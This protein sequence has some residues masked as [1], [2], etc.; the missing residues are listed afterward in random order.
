MQPSESRTLSGREVARDVF[1]LPKS[2]LL[3]HLRREGSI[4]GLP[5]IRIGRNWIFPRSAI[6]RLLPPCDVSGNELARLLNKPKSTLF[7]HLRKEGHINGVE[8]IRIG[9]HYRF[10][11]TR[12]EAL[13]AGESQDGVAND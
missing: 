9:R 1:D 6:E 13:L 10:S 2:T 8:P 4:S 7:A 12:I 11:R 5:A 3:A